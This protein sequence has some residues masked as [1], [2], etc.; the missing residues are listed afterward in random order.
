MHQL[1]SE[2]IKTFV[3]CNEINECMSE[4]RR[5][6]QVAVAVS[7][8]HARA[9]LYDR[10]A[11]C[12]RSAANIRNNL[13]VLKMNETS[14]HP[15]EWNGLIRRVSEAGLVAKWSRLPVAPASNSMLMSS[16]AGFIT[17][18]HYIGCLTFVAIGWFLAILLAILEQIIH[19]KV[20]H[21]NRHRYWDV[22]DMLIDGQR[23]MFIFNQ[24]GRYRVGST[25]AH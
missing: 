5:S 13:V 17:T 21:L 24:G 12:F 1:T 14:I 19:Y 11:Y 15:A 16:D 23:H 9:T 18:E 20:K 4:L 10:Y 8:Y 25:E 6:D 2:Q 3:I 22:A 7:R